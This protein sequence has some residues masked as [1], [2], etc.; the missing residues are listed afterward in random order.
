MATATVTCTVFD[1]QPK[2]LEDGVISVSGSYNSGATAL[3]TGD[4]V[5]LAK[6]PHGAKYVSF[7]A[8]HS[9]G[10][11]AHACDY[12]YAKGGAAGGGASLSALVAA[13]AQAAILRKTVLG[14]PADISCSDS[15]PN[16][17]GILAAK[18]GVTGTTTT[19]LII[20]FTY[21]YRCDGA[22]G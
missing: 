3:S 13:G 14:I 10:A 15:D 18:V 1:A 4:I 12:G 17:W 19:S 16:R 6:L 5:F 21:C 22:G 20:N 7:E 8:D 2:Y 11:T 9:T